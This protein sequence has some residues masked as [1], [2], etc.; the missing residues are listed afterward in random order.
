MNALQLIFLTLSFATIQSMPP[1]APHYQSSPRPTE[2]KHSGDGTSNSKSLSFSQI[3][4]QNSAAALSH[5]QTYTSVSP[6]SGTYTTK[7]C[8]A[9]PQFGGA[10]SAF[11]PTIHPRK[12]ILQRAGFNMLEMVYSSDA[13]STRADESMQVQASQ[14]SRD[15]SDTDSQPKT[16]ARSQDS[17]STSPAATS[18]PA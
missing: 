10:S 12:S 2:R 11:S 5:L 14:S 13:K 6:S 4:A 18:K 7:P 8:G 16:S 17:R 9:K 1:A 15:E 3:V